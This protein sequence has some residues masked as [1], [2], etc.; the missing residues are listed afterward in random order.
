[1]VVLQLEQ[2]DVRVCRNLVE[3][4][5][6][7]CGTWRHWSTADREQPDLDL[8]SVASAAAVVATH[9]IVLQ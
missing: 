6:R 5:N 7:D 1:V 9:T 3:S 4:S 8:D 2:I